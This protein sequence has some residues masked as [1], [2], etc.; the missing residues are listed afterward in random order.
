MPAPLIGQHNN[1]VIG[2]LL[3]LSREEV[4]QGYEDG[5]F[6]PTDMPK[7]PYVEEALK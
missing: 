2:G 7:F 4:L 5:T 3:G 1:E 6:W